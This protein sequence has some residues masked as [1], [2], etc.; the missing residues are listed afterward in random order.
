MPDDP[1]G[2]PIFALN[3][4]Q[5]AAA[6]GFV[7]VADFL[8]ARQ[9]GHFPEPARDVPGVGPSGRGSRSRRGLLPE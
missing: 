7:R 6:A 8:Q 5:T 9:L 2:L 3:E 4:V 1:P